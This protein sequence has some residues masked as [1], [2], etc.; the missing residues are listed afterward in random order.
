LLVLL[1]E[2]AKDSAMRLAE[3]IRH[4]IEAA[5]INIGQG[6]VARVTV[7]IGVAVYN[8]HP[9]YQHMIKQADDAMYEA[10]HQGRNRVTFANTAVDSDAWRHPKI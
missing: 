3:N 6:R 1:V 4:Q 2:V 5:A 9:D 8:G 7:S 10:K